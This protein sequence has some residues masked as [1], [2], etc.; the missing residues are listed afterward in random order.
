MKNIFKNFYLRTTGPVSTKFG[1]KHPLVE[2]MEIFF[3]NKEPCSFTRGDN[4][5][6]GGSR[7]SGKGVDFFSKAWGLGPAQRPQVGPG[8]RPGGGPRGRGP[9]KL[10]N[11]IF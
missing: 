8:Q 4:S 1:I 7:N 10:L 9:R 6:M 5:Y 3:S 2:G 11:F